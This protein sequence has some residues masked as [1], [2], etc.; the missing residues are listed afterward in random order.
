VPARVAGMQGTIPTVYGS[1]RA[2]SGSLRF[3][4]FAVGQ[5]RNIASVCVAGHVVLCASCQGHQIGESLQRDR[6]PARG[7]QRQRRHVAGQPVIQGGFRSNPRL[8]GEAG[9]DPGRRTCSTSRNARY[10]AISANTG[11]GP[12]CLHTASRDP[13]PVPFAPRPATPSP[14]ATGHRPRA[15][16]SEPTTKRLPRVR[17]KRRSSPLDQAMAHPT[18]LSAAVPSWFC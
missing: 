7:E 10:W 4:R 2:C 9:H 15:R 12:R 13:R 14:V 16:G 6:R 11:T 1:G 3:L 5:I 17:D 18:A 8:G